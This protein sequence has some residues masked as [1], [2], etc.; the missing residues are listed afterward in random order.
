MKDVVAEVAVFT[1]RAG[2]LEALLLRR[3]GSV[4]ALPGGPV[5]EGV[6]VERAALG[7]LGSQTGVRGIALEQLYTL[8]RPP[9]GLAVAFLAL[10]ASARHPISPG[11]DVVEV[12]WFALGDLPPLAEEAA[13]VLRYAQARLRAKT[14]Y[15]PIAF[16]LLPD[17]FTLGELQAVY[18]AVLGAPLDTRN[19][20]RD[21]LAAGVVEPVDGVRAEGRGRPARLYRSRAGDFAVVARERRIARALHRRELDD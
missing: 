12:R 14:T 4:W 16:Q 2:R 1:V 19:F 20:R 21:V 7:A 6:T 5:G 10:I 8:D 3:R 17:A 13:E 18:E 9:D 15:A 11:L